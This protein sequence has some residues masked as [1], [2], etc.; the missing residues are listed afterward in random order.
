MWLDRIVGM[1]DMEIERHPTG[2]LGGGCLQGIQK[3]CLGWP[4]LLG[5]SEGQYLIVVCNFHC[6]KQLKT[7]SE[8]FN[9]LESMF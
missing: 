2:T 4:F 7:F 6:L 1:R 8:K 9:P 5:A 3:G